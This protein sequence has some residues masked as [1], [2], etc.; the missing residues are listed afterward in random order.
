ML[1]QITPKA[2]TTS[3]HA[4]ES[5]IWLLI[6]VGL[7]SLALLIPAGVAGTSWYRNRRARALFGD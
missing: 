3:A 1:D 7:L 5:P 6:P 4:K 2:S